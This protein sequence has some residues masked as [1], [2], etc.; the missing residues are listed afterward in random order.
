MDFMEMRLRAIRERWRAKW[1]A[2]YYRKLASRRLAA[3]ERMRRL[4]Q[5]RKAL[6]LHQGAA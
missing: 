2:D 6:S 1:R 4:R 5:T 3:R